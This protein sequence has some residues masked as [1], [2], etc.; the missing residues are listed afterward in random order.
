MKVGLHQP[1]V[2]PL[3]IELM[4]PGDPNAPAGDVV[5]CRCVVTVTFNN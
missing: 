5:N 4:Y 3:G 2:T 1:F